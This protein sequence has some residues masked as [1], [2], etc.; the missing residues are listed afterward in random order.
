V[1]VGVVLAGAVVPVLRGWLVGREPFQPVLIIRQQAVLGVID[2]NGSGAMRCPFA[3]CKSRPYEDH[4]PIFGN[5][6]KPSPKS[7]KP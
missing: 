4:T 5:A 6:G 2:E 3:T 7:L 1:S